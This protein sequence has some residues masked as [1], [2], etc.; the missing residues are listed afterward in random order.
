MKRAD[1]DAV[2]RI[3][4]QLANVAYNLSGRPGQNIADHERELMTELVREWDTAKHA[5]RSSMR[6]PMRTSIRRRRNV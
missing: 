5:L 6:R 1:I 4:Q 2:L 3:G